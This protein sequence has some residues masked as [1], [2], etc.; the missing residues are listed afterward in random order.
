M[1]VISLNETSQ[2][3]SDALRG[4]S[5]GEYRIWLVTKKDINVISDQ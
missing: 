3:I 4:Y 1:R 5:L 2:N